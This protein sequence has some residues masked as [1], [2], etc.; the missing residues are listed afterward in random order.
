[1]DRHLA[2]ALRARG[3]DLVAANEIAMIGRQDHEQ[4]AYA[5][6]EGRAIYTFN[7]PDFCRLHA[8]W[9]AAGKPHAGIIVARQQTYSVGEQMRRL[10]KLI[11][12][13]SAEDMANR[14][15]FLSDWA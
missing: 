8:E 4:L 10:L 12:T 1:M 6:T 11:T 2:R 9:I 7:V 5:A 14:L 13:R 15:E 3:A